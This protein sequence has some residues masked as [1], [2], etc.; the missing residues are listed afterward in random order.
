MTVIANLCLGVIGLFPLFLLT[1]YVSNLGRAGGAPLGWTLVVVPLTVGFGALWF[2]VNRGLRK[3]TAPA[4]A[5]RHWWLAVLL[6]SAPALC[7]PVG[8]L[9]SGA[10]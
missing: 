10:F 8:A 9:V 6:T 1:V 4:P 5:R 7:L 3:L 2:L